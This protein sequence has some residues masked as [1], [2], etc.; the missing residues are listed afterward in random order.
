V[1]GQRNNLTHGSLTGQVSLRTYKNGSGSF[2]YAKP[3]RFVTS[4]VCFMDVEDRIA[5]LE[6]IIVQEDRFRRIEWLTMKT[7]GLVT[8]LLVALSVVAV[9]V[10][11]VVVLIIHLVSS[12]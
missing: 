2:D 9:A 11:H 3:S 1:A 12:K 10:A 5:K 7:V 8:F 4:G 6:Q